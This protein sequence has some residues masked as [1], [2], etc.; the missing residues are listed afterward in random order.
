MAKP[1]R[2]FI[3]SPGDVVPER[4]RAALVIE[5]L[6]KDYARFFEIEP[7]LWETEPMLAS[8]HFQD[9]IVPPGETDIVVLILWARLGTPLPEEKYRGIDGRAPVTGTEWEFEAALAA[10]KQRGVP[11]LL[12]YKKKAPPKAEYT[13]EADLEE[14]GRQLQKFGAFWSRHFVDHGEFRAA[15]GEFENL[16][17]FEAK[18]EGDL[19]RLIERRIAALQAQPDKAVSPTW[20]KGSPFRGL[21]IY[22]FEHAPIFFGRSEATK[23]AVEQLVENAEAGRPFLL[24][25]GASGSGKSSLVQAGIVPVLGVR[26]VVAGVGEWRRAVIRPGGHPGGP[27]M[28]L[29]AAFADDDALPEVL[30]GQ[31]VAALARHLE[32][33]AADPSFP[34]VAALAAR[35]QAARQKGDLLSFEEVRLIL[36]VDQ[37]EELFTL[38]EM[39]PDQR[40]VFIVCL[41]GLMDSRRVFVIATMRSDYWH[42]A[43]E[44]PLL[45]ALAEGHGRL[46]LLPPTQAEIT[47][48]I[49]RPAEA[50]GLSFETD[51]RT[52]IGLDAALAEEASREP[53]ALP[54][55]SF[56]LS[57]LYARDV[58]ENQGSALRYA[59]MR[60]LGGLKGAIATRA[61]TAFTGLPTDAQAVLPKVLRAL[62]TVSRSGAEPTARAVSMARV[63][64]GSLERR[65]VEAFLDPQ[66]RLLVADGD[67]EGARVRLAHEALITHWERAKRQIAQDRDDLGTRAVVEEA[68]AE[69]RAAERRDKRG[70]LLRDP[71]LANAV[72]LAKRWGDELDAPLREFIK[73]SARRARLAQTLTAAAAVLFAIVAGAAFYLWHRA[74]D[75]A[76]IALARQLAAQAGLVM[77]ESPDLQDRSVLLALESVRRAA[78]FEGSQA[79]R[80]AL[81]GLAKLRARF[82]ISGN[83]HAITFSPDGQYLAVGS[84]DKTARVF[85]IAENREV[86]RF[87]HEDPVTSVVFNPNGKQIATAAGPLA[88]IFD[89][90]GN[91]EVARVILTDRVRTL[92]FSQ[93]GNLL[94]VGGDDKT[95]RVVDTT[96]GREITRFD[97]NRPVIKVDFSATGHNLAILGEVDKSHK[98]LRIV[99]VG[100]GH[101]VV[102]P[103]SDQLSD[104]AVS[105]DGS[106]LVAITLHDDAR[107]ARVLELE[108][109]AEVLQFEVG[110]P[111]SLSIALS[112][113]GAYLILAAMGGGWSLYKVE[114]GATAPVLNWRTRS[115][116]LRVQFLG[117]H[118][119]SMAITYLDR[120]TEIIDLL[121]MHNS[122]VLLHSIPGGVAF[123]P[124]GDAAAAVTDQGGTLVL[125]LSVGPTTISANSDISA[126]RFDPNVRYLAAFKQ[127]GVDS[128]TFFDPKNGRR[129]GAPLEEKGKVDSIAF[130]ADGQYAAI[131][132]STEPTQ[133]IELKSRHE[134]ARLGEHEGVAAIAFSGDGR[135]VAIGVDTGKD[136]EVGAWMF[137][138]TTWKEVQPLSSNSVCALAFTADGRHVA[139]GEDNFV[140]FC[141]LGG[142]SRLFED[143][144]A[145][146][147][148]KATRERRHWVGSGRHHPDAHVLGKTRRPIIC[149][150]LAPEEI[151]ISPSIGPRCSMR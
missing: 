138:T 90:D 119:R 45:V 121:T 8:G 35:E 22:R 135:R 53:G 9:A 79:L 106:R 147:G 137:D 75:E 104:A 95:A 71:Y 107:T 142:S 88:R 60:T 21:E 151:E 23:T 57:A 25:L 132:L 150:V 63:A 143:V 124:D 19:R 116:I 37:L 33:A 86:A 89:L 133:V 11:D 4:R 49:R 68:E 129:L 81:K 134:V 87:A 31:D 110:G 82:P 62:V 56:L 17:G 29:A 6:A 77:T 70:Y 111:A 100:S 105:G 50:A 10:H 117:L 65:I 48:M 58:Q 74:S 96:T 122:A 126:A 16:D 92:A 36:V 34:I 15:F 139:V 140:G 1:L 113:D 93:D 7:Y 146:G 41:K 85:A 108:N 127:I 28:A 76:A 80:S 18:L 55:L 54:L 128:I 97:E 72:D 84:E 148:R 136:N 32:A 42:R 52:E 64:E 83:N 39:T 3:S 78:S 99:E 109:G 14:L 61:E 101:D 67:G 40:K 44:V 69:W 38:G 103:I 114:K 115:G 131:G 141:S 47:E 46:D 144:A 27:F 145:A 112:R 94:A 5:K 123:S 20:L 73:L 2:I 120:T 118:L 59:S 66:V 24:V 130:S 91:R 149:S 30:K 26:G 98:T 12:A 51:P 13:S 43:A 125:D 102:P